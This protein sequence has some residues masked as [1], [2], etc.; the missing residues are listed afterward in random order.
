MTSHRAVFDTYEVIASRNVYLSDDLF[1]KT[2]KINSIVVEVMMK[3][4][5]KRIYIKIS[6]I[7]P[8]YK[9]ICSR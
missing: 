3:D 4:I 1:M 7:C 9:Q 6:Y 5:I 2:I 8:S